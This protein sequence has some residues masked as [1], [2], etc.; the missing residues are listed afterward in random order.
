MNKQSQVA[1]LAV[2]GLLI[3]FC[4]YAQ[5]TGYWRTSGSQILDSN[6]HAVRIAGINW[7]GFE[8][9]T[10]VV[11]GLSSQDYKSILN[12]IHANGYNTIRIPFSN[13]MVE[14]GISPQNIS[15][16][17][18]SG[19]INTDLSGLSSLQVLDKIVAYAGTLGLRIIL[20]NHRSEA[21]DSAEANGL[22]Y[23]SSYPESAWIGDWQALAKRY[24]ENTTVIGAD[25][26]N[27]PHN[28]NSGGSCW[29]CGS[30]TNDW[31]LAA[32]RGGNAV[33]AI[34][35]Q[36]LIFVEGTDEFNNDYDWWGGNLEGAQSYPVTLSVSNQLVYSAHDYGPD[37]YGQ[38]WFNSSTTYSSLTAVWTK[39]WAYL[40]LN[41]VAPVWLGEF[42]TTNNSSDIANSSPGSQGQWFQ[43]TIQFL[44]ANQNLSW[45]YWAL[46]GEDEFAL[47]DSNYDS[48]PVSA[49]KQQALAS[50]QFT[51]GA[52]TVCASAP[53]TPSGLT[54]LPSSAS[55]ITLSWNAVTTPAGCSITY[56][57]YASQSAGFTPAQSNVVASG[58]TSP[59]YTY[60][61][62]ASGATWYFAVSALDA[63]GQSSPSPIQS[64]TT[65]TSSPQPPSAPSNLVAS[66]TSSSTI[67]LTWQASST[68]GV[69]YNVY[70]S[71]TSGATTASSTRIASG[72]TGTSYINSGLTA[73]TTYYYLVTAASSN[74]ESSPSNQAN[75]TT[76][77]ATLSG[78]SCH[79]VYTTNSVWNVGFNVGITIENT[80]TN[81]ITSWALT[82]SWPSNE[83]VSQAWNS[84]LFSG[85]PNVVLTSASWN[86]SISPGT[87]ISGVGLNGSYTGSYV[88]PSAFYLNGTLCK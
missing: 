6:G 61:G 86:G 67:S 3:S 4:C 48:A 69:T 36:W 78:S 80:G 76:Q 42:G 49:Q 52:G 10:G 9:T 45:T 11:H 58:L 28:A 40:S 57:I 72:I 47:L 23:T 88:Q 75:A 17:N 53:A 63:A 44:H 83:T 55:A 50:I 34:N 66:A 24:L 59:P 30:S 56:D 60:S 71:A 29:G 54:A 7:Y 51:L 14:G 35:P 31:R 26:R 21:G 32:E 16:N 39:F 33:L 62:L 38:S 64:A 79:V 37:L 70:R 19:P 74:G 13:Q 65:Q 20:D 46:N 22:W 27:E 73:S 12:T 8:T 41:N 82:W 2:A 25:L 5:G 43:S 68:S 87:T 85:G 81:A 18:S 84:N 77:P 15:Y 1:R